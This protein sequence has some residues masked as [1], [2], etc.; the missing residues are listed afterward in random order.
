MEMIKKI[1]Q[2]RNMIEIDYLF[3]IFLNTG[4]KEIFHILYTYI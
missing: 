4:W 2:E 3:P 1:Q